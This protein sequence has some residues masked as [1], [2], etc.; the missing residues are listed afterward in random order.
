MSKCPICK[1]A[2]CVWV[3]LKPDPSKVPTEKIKQV[4]DHNDS[5]IEMIFKDGGSAAA[6]E[7]MIHRLQPYAEELEK[8][9]SK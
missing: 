5:Y 6:E 9:Q 7:R 2:K 4:M 3:E 1:R 8:R